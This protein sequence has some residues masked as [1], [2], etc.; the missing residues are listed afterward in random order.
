MNRFSDSNVLFPRESPL[1]I[2]YT[3]NSCSASYQ[4]SF[5]GHQFLEYLSMYDP[6]V[7]LRLNY[8]FYLQMEKVVCPL[9]KI[10]NIIFDS[11]TLLS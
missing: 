10:L 2:V 3:I 4:V 7:N 9:R 11:L 6:T 1:K 8:A 5:Y